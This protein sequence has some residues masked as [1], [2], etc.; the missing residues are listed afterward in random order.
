L[1]E[2]SEAT[3]GERT[4][5]FARLDTFSQL[6]VLRRLGPA[7]VG[8]IPALMAFLDTSAATP[9]D[10][11]AEVLEELLRGIPSMVAALSEMSDESVEYV[12][13]K[14]FTAVYVQQGQ[15]WAPLRKGTTTM[16]ADLDLAVTGQIV[17]QVLKESLGGFFP[18]ELPKG[19]AA[20][21]QASDSPTSR[22]GPTS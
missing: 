6:H 22:T 18:T 1:S 7:F 5:R 8:A 4:Y 21:A 9:E 15:T 10:R 19:F 12:V 11:K 20:A 3:I 13:N 16:F 14:C 17:F 2:F